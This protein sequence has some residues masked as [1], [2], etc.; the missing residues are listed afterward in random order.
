[1]TAIAVGAAFF[2]TCWNTR[3]SLRPLARKASTNSCDSR[4]PTSARTVR[5]TMPIGITDMVTAGRIRYWKCSQSQAQPPG[6]APTAGSQPR[7]TENTIT[8][9]MPSQ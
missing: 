7:I 5:L 2:S 4:S 3:F 9:T 6:P 1:M 8:S